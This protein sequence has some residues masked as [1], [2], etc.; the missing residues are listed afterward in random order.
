MFCGPLMV[1]LEKADASVVEP[2]TESQ[3]AYEGGASI[4]LIRRLVAA[5][6]LEPEPD[7]RFPARYIRRVRLIRGFDQSGLPIA[8]VRQ[9]LAEGFLD[10]DLG[11]AVWPPAARRSPRTA[12]EFRDSLGDLGEL[13]SQVWAIFGFPDPTPDTR[14]LA[15]DEAILRRF[16]DV[17]GDDPAIAARAA[18]LAAD[19]MRHLVEGWNRLALRLYEDPVTDGV[20]PSEDVRRRAIGKVAA[21]VRLT[22]D[23]VG[24][25][26]QRYLE[27]VSAATSM[28]FLEAVLPDQT[29]GTVPAM[30]PAIV[31]AD[32]AG[33]TDLTQRLGDAYAVG[34]SLRL[35]EV[36]EGAARQEGGRLVKLLGDGA[37]L[38]FPSTDAACRGS[39]RLVGTWPADLPALH[40]GIGVGPLLERD[41]DYFGT[42]VNLAARLSA[43]ASPGQILAGSLGGEIHLDADGLR[44]VGSLTLKGLPQPVAAL[45][46]LAAAW[47]DQVE[48]DVRPNSR[49]ALS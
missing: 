21:L 33:F 5:G 7:G 20:T 18:R 49:A 47:L 45:E 25:L 4:D 41:G 10:F 3:L 11:D 40:I 38:V 39:A 28:E 12:L 32:L 14:L 46:V 37:M 13:G 31:F 29:V 8:R 42:T 34:L 6:I 23:T 43:A 48:D 16:L 17:W 26:E 27:E 44:S 22:T 9:A 19:S 30:Q 1:D 15:E 36:S 24:W 2:L 35:R